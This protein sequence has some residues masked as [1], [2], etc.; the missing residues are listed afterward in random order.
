MSQ[1]KAQLLVLQVS[2]MVLKPCPTTIGLLP[3]ICVVDV[4]LSGLLMS[5]LPVAA[6]PCGL[7]LTV[8]VARLVSV[9]GKASS[10]GLFAVCWNATQNTHLARLVETLVTVTVPQRS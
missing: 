1:G 6:K 2:A 9:P 4:L 3:A 8:V 5:E 7:L 10:V